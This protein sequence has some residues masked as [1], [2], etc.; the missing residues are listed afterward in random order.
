MIPTMLFVVFAVGTFLS[1]RL[2]AAG[3]GTDSH[4][5][6]GVLRQFVGNTAFVQDVVTVKINLTNLDSLGDVLKTAKSEIDNLFETDIRITSS[7]VNRL[8]KAQRRKLE[9]LFPSRTKRALF[10]WGGD[11]LHSIFGT[12]TDDEVH[13]VKAKVE[14]LETWAQMKGS[15][16]SKVVKRLNT[17]SSLVTDL[18]NAVANLSHALNEEEISMRHTLVRNSLYSVTSSLSFMLENFVAIQNAVVLAHKNI[19]SPDLLAP[20]ELRDILLEAKDKHG[21]QLLYPNNF[22]KYYSVLTAKVV[23]GFIYVFVPF[24]SSFQLQLFKLIPFPAYI[25][26]SIVVKLDISE[27]FI[28]I[29]ENFDSIA[30]PSDDLIM[31]SC[32]SVSSNNYLCPANKLHFFP[33]AQHLCLLNIAV[34]NNITNSCTYKTDTDSS[35][36]VRHVSPFHY[37]FTRRLVTITLKCGDKAPEMTDVRGNF[38]IHDDCGVYAPNLIRIFPSHSTMTSASPFIPI[39]DRVILHKFE[40]PTG[41]RDVVLQQITTPEPLEEGLDLYDIPLEDVHPYFSFVGIPILMIIVVV[42]ICIFTRLVYFKK[43]AS[44]TRTVKGLNE[45]MKNEAKEES[46]AE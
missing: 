9:H 5:T 25:N 46:S 11:I 4:L 14:R 38:Q 19:V 2:D 35:I 1:Q 13:N 8:L 16:I 41:H 10:K 7:R 37:F 39:K 30:F 20:S 24:K 3:T 18:S 26:D 34:H 15:L 17:Q 6:T 27:M 23:A 22:N 21:F 43:I 42:G 29:T 32:L 40:L 33:S 28:L 31:H 36:E 45:R 44:M 12:A